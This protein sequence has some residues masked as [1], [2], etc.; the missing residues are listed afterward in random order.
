MLENLHHGTCDL[1]DEDSER[2]V[3]IDTTE[4]EIDKGLSI[5]AWIRLMAQH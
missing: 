4:C 2:F 5:E 1:L 3:Y